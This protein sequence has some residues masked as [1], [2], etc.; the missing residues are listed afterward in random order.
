M[1]V[2]KPFRLND[3]DLLVLEELDKE[4]LFVL[5]YNLDIVIS[6]SSQFNDYKISR[7]REKCEN[8]FKKSSFCAYSRLINLTTMDGYTEY[9]TLFVK[10]APLTFEEYKQYSKIIKPYLKNR[11]YWTATGWNDP[12]VY[13]IGEN[14]VCGIRVNGTIC[15]IPVNSMAYF[16]PALII[17]SPRRGIHSFTTEELIKELYERSQSPVNIAAKEIGVTL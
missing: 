13:D 10:A 15:E 17:D 12:S 9:E 2:G 8:W 16:L 3:T 1:E 7:L 11:I 6:F 14:N 4:K 5:A